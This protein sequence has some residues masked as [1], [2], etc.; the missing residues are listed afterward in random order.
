MLREFI[1]KLQSAPHERKRIWMILFTAVVMMAVIYVWLAY[2]NNLVTSLSRPAIARTPE[3]ES[4]DGFSFGQTMK[5][6]AAAIYSF[7]ADKL[8]GLIGVLET[9]R[10]YIIKP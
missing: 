9:P 7:L 6:G 8:K 4:R 10:E 2:F 5:N 1:E 3:I